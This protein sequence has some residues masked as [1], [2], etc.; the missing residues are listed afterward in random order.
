M[1][2]GLRQRLLPQAV[3]IPSP[4]RR[5]IAST[6]RRDRPDRNARVLGDA[7]RPDISPN[8]RWSS[9]ASSGT[10]STA[11]RG[12]IR[13]RRRSRSN[14]RRPCTK[15]RTG[16]TPTSRR[17]DGGNAPVGRPLQHPATARQALGKREL[18]GRSGSSPDRHATPGAGNGQER[19]GRVSGRQRHVLSGPTVSVQQ[20]CDG[21]A[22]AG[23]QRGAVRRADSRA[24]IRALACD[25]V[26]RDVHRTRRLARRWS[27]RRWP[28]SRPTIGED[29]PQVA[30]THRC[31]RSC[32]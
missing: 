6:P 12:R 4:D 23:A 18:F 19:G 31:E 17:I 2:R 13:T 30:A 21:I 14:C 22:A 7:R 11:P 29:S 25:A 5:V 16:M 20:L 24:A 8:G 3:A 1:A 15:P 28:S 9:A 10:R 32:T 26:H 27:V